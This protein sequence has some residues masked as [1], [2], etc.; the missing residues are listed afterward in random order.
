[1]ETK[2]GNF[3]N[4]KNKI[5]K[6]KSGWTGE[7]TITITVTGEEIK[8]S[9]DAEKYLNKPDQ[10]KIWKGNSFVILKTE[11]DIRYKYTNEKGKLISNGRI[12]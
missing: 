12:M 9:T 4:E 6:T 2:F 5:E 7:K 3:L 1:M 8:N 10:K 11:D